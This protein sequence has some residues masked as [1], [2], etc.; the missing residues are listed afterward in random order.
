MVTLSVE[1]KLVPLGGVKVGVATVDAV[2]VF[3]KP[4]N[5]ADTAGAF[6]GVLLLLP[7]KGPR[8]V[9]TRLSLKLPA[10]VQFTASAEEYAV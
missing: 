5:A 6:A 1:E 4:P 9:T 10:E 8:W 2:G 7:T 3:S